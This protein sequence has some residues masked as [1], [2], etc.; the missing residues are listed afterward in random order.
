M[1]IEDMFLHVTEPAKPDG[2]LRK[3]RKYEVKTRSGK[4]L[5][6]EDVA[7]RI[8]RKTA[9]VYQLL[10]S[11]P[12]GIHGVNFQ[13]MLIKSAARKY[14]RAGQDAKIIMATHLGRNVENLV[15]FTAH[16]EYCALERQ[17]QRELV[18]ARAAD[19]YMAD[20]QAWQEQEQTRKLR[21]ASGEHVPAVQPPARPIRVALAAEMGTKCSCGRDAA[22]NAVRESLSACSVVSHNGASSEQ[23]ISNEP[24]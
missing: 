13:D 6:V 10:R 4:V 23:P 18:A 22:I 2:S 17:R 19:R 21:R 1:H 12:L 8:G 20:W 11:L 15:S 9:T 24:A 5:G 14:Q 3:Q 16:A 7:A